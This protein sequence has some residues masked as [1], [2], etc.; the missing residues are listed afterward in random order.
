MDVSRAAATANRKPI[1]MLIKHMKEDFGTLKGKH[2]ALWGLAFKPRTDDVREAPALALAK[3]L[4]DAGATV[5]GT[6]PE[7][8]ETSRVALNYLGIQG[9]E[10]VKDQYEVTRGADALVLC[11]EWKQYAAPNVRKLTQLMRG[12][13]VYDGRNIWIPEEFKEAGFTYLGIG[14]K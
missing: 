3:E 11:T 14:R 12:R 7:A 10:L 13:R 2:F 6:D 9:V 1:D 5:A 8:L 4:I